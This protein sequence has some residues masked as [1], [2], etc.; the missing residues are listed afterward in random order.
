[1]PRAR[2]AL[3]IAALLSPAPGAALAQSEAYAIDSTDALSL[4]DL[5]TGARTDLVTLPAIGLAEGLAVTDDKSTIYITNSDGL[6]FTV[7]VATLSITGSADL[8]LGNIEGLDYRNGRLMAVSFGS[9]PSLY[10]VDPVAGV[11]TLVGPLGVSVPS[12]ARSFAMASDTVGYIVDYDSLYRIDLSTGAGTP[13]GPHASPEPFFGIDFFD[14]RL[15]AIASTSGAVSEIDTA[16][17]LA[18]PTGAPAL[19]PTFYLGLAGMPE[20]TVLAI[21]GEL[22]ASSPAFDRPR[23]S[24]LLPDP[25]VTPAPDSYNDGQPFDA[26]EIS[27]VDPSFPVTM[28]M[29]SLEPALADFDPYL[30]FYCDFSP[31]SPLAGVFYR[32]DDSGYDGNDATRQNARMEFSFGPGA[33]GTLVATSYASWAPARYGRYELVITNGVATPVNPCPADVNNDGILDNG[34][35]GAFV[36]LFLAGDPA[37]DFNNDGIL[38]N[39]DIGAFVAAFLAGC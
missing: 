4:V 1:M 31:A 37:A 12:A 2:H 28:E 22:T 32:D 11:A 23:G 30:V 25:C 18:T 9:A 36:T 29:R 10:D 26:Y 6:L 19:P 15:L 27:A 8:G 5:D 16:T 39:G 24:G 13:V 20:P 35:I 14:G 34:D 3:A 17:G 38:D 21:P 7:D 33:V